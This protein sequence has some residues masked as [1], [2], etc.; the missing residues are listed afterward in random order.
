MYLF[1]RPVVGKGPT[2]S[3]L[4]MVNGAGAGSLIVMGAL[5]VLFIFLARKHMSHVSIYL[6]ISLFIP[7]QK[8]RGII[9]EIIFA[10]PT[11]PPNGE[12]W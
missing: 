4:S 1:P 7:L 12:S 10:I 6:A 11:W 5:G 3:K 9:A 2:A 8:I